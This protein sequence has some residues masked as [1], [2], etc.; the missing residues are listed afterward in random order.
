MGEELKDFKALKVFIATPGNLKEERQEFL[1]V[2]QAHNIEDAHES[3]IVFLPSGWEFAYGGVGRPQAL[4]NQQVR[5]SDYLIVAFWD[6]WGK[7]TSELGEYTSGTQE[8]F[9]IGMECLADP[10]SPM[11]D[12]IVFFKGVSDKQLSDPGDQLAQ[13]L[14]FKKELEESRAA[15][16]TEFDDP[17][18]FRAQLR[19]HLNRWTRDW[20]SGKVPPKAQLV[21]PPRKLATEPETDT[22]ALALG[23]AGLVEEAVRLAAGG[24]NTEAEQLFAQAITTGDDIN[25]FAQY[26]L[27]LRKGGRY[28]AA[29]TTTNQQLLLARE[30]GNVNS[31]I[32][33]LNNLGVIHRLKGQKGSSAEYLRSALKIV[34]ERIS[35]EGEK[36]EYLTQK[37]HL[38]DGLALTLRK[39]PEKIAE[40]REALD[41]SIALRM[42]ASDER[43]RAFTLRTLGALLTQIGDL[44]AARTALDES[45][46]VFDQEGYDR[47]KAQAL[48][49]L[50][51]VLELM[52]ELPQAE[53]RFEEALALNVAMG[54]V[55]GRSINLSELSRVRLALGLTEQ[56]R[57]DAISCITINERSG[58]PEGLA[59]GLHALGRV[60]MSE[61][62]LREADEHLNQAHTLF[63]DLKQPVGIAATALDL[64]ELSMRSGK[65][66]EAEGNLRLAL[67]QLESSP[68]YGLL[69]IARRI[70][71]TLRESD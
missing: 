51:E 64:A 40:A 52:G 69:D 54:S 56:A 3:E 60:L 6:W 63:V 32:D 47:G 4:I 42:R 55:Q 44:G 68:H 41:E 59:A 62:Q 45:V 25:A 20:A 18:E 11:R 16:Y 9:A 36:E 24:R 70:E 65:R 10:E 33:A 28:S 21:R 7:P 2:V 57:E 43:G 12:V 8:E 35:R 50:G 30:S 38:L 46:S 34:N 13:V 37:A 48:A 23:T 31:E 29:E 26:A 39:T 22:G 14:K 5:E 71:R 53:E 61:G 19:R 49:S 15:L 58:N 67:N 1:S 27:F 66:L 17:S